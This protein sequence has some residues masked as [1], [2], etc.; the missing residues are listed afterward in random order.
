MRDLVI[1]G[2]W[3]MIP[4]LLCSIA[5]F[6]IM[7]ERMWSLRRRHIIPTDVLAHVWQTWQ[8]SQSSTA[9]MQSLKDS[10]PMANILV[11]GLE[12]ARLGRELMKQ[13]IE[14]A[15]SHVIHDMEKFLNT[16]GTIAAIAPLLGL[17]GTVIGMIKVFSA[18]VVHGSGDTGVLAGGISQA[19]IT[20][21]AGLVIAIPSLFAHRYLL[22][23]IDELSIE[24]EAEAI[25]LIDTFFA[26]KINGSKES[27]V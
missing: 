6:A 10:S 23:Y 12:N 14:E 4:I 26:E 9:T 25:K 7:A 13:R 11:T 21:A 5:A 19:L 22:R 15:A 16:L 18:I 17:L 24:M 20:T 2:G 8:K 1:A 3:I 27:N